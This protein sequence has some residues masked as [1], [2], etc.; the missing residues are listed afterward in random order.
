MNNVAFRVFRS[1]GFSDL[2]IEPTA[3][4][5]AKFA[6]SLQA[7]QLISISHVIDGHIHIITVWHWENSAPVM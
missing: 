6:S 1:E 5:A 2:D 3:K 7:E 4:Q